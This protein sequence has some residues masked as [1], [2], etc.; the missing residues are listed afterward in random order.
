MYLF[1]TKHCT[2][3]RALKG[4]AKHDTKQHCNAYAMGALKTQG[5]EGMAIF[6]GLVDGTS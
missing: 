6:T 2:Q 4:C 1:L 3:I 5:F